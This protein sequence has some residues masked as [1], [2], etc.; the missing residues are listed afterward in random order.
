MN[1]GFFKARID[2]KGKFIFANEKAIR[3]LGFTNFEELSK[4]HILGLLADPDER[5]SIRKSLTETGLLKNKVLKILKNNGDYSIISFSLVLLNKENSDDLICDG[6]IED[7]T[8]EE[9]EKIQ[10]TN[11]ITELKTND[12]ILEQPVKDYISPVKSMD[13]DSTLEMLLIF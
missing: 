5:K 11:L 6:I 12:F 4:S 3:I 10:T 2:S 9:N 8:L 1:I 13:S 7:I